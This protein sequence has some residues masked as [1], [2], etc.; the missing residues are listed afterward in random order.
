VLVVIVLVGRERM[1]RWVAPVR[2]LGE[3]LG[4]PR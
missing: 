3:R 1:A 2:L 4:R